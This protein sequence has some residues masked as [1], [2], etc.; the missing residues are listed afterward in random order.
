MQS[1]VREDP[2]SKSRVL[3]GQ[4]NRSEYTDF[5][6]QWPKTEEREALSG[7]NERFAGFIEKVRQLESENKVLENEIEQLREKQAT[8]STLYEGMCEAEIKELREIVCEISSQKTK[9]EIGKQNLEEDFS[10]LSGRYENEAQK[11]ANTEAKIA[12][13]K[14]DLS[15]TRLSKIDLETKLQ[16]LVEEI[17]LLKENHNQEVSELR[18]HIQDAQLTVEENFAKPDITATLKDIREQLAGQSNATTQ[19]TEQWF[20]T[21]MASMAQTAD[22]N[23]QALQ[24][25]KDH[26]QELKRQWRTKSGELERARKIKDKLEK[27]IQDLEGRHEVDIAQYRETVQLLENELQVT[28]A[29]IYGHLKEHQEL[30]NIKMA[31]DVEIT[32]YRKLLEDEEFRFCTGT[33]DLL[34][35]RALCRQPALYSVPS[36]KK[37][38][39][40]SPIQELQSKSIGDTITEAT[41][42]D[43]LTE[44]EDTDAEDIVSEEEKLEEKIPEIEDFRDKDVDLNVGKDNEDKIKLMDYAGKDDKVNDK[45]FKQDKQTEDM[46]VEQSEEKED[47]MMTTEIVTTS[48]TSSL[49]EQTVPEN[50]TKSAENETP[51]EEEESSRESDVTNMGDEQYEEHVLHVE[52]EQNRQLQDAMLQ[53]ECPPS[54]EEDIHEEPH[55]E[56]EISKES[57][58]SDVQSTE[59]QISHEDLKEEETTTN[60]MMRESHHKAISKVNVDAET[61]HEASREDETTKS[62]Q[63]YLLEDSKVAKQEAFSILTREEQ[64]ENDGP[65]ED[66]EEITY[67]RKEVS[68]ETLKT[69]NVEYEEIS[70]EN[71]RQKELKEDNETKKELEQ[72]TKEIG[73]QKPEMSMSPGK[74]GEYHDKGKANVILEDFKTEEDGST[75]RITGDDE[76]VTEPKYDQ[77]GKAEEEETNTL[78]NQTLS[79]GQ[80][81]GMEELE[82][83][84]VSSQVFSDDGENIGQAVRDTPSE[85]GQGTALSVQEQREVSPLTKTEDSSDKKESKA[86]SICHPE[87]KELKQVNQEEEKKCSNMV[88]INDEQLTAKDK[89]L[90][91]E[92]N[93]IGDQVSPIQI[94]EM[95]Q[96]EEEPATNSKDEPKDLQQEGA[97][98]HPEQEMA[99][100]AESAQSP[101]TDFTPGDH[102]TI[103]Q[104]EFKED[105]SC[106]QDIHTGLGTEET[107]AMLCDHREEVCKSST[108]KLH[109]MEIGSKEEIDLGK[110]TT[111]TTQEIL[112]QNEG[113]ELPKESQEDECSTTKDIQEQEESASITQGAPEQ[114]GRGEDDG[115]ESVHP[116]DYYKKM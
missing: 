19:Q 27:Q 37:Q 59:R 66:V 108:G 43:N 16:A 67:R 62:R 23:S 1:S 86:E 8:S 92:R 68:S 88:E 26:I 72:A 91:S 50:L 53:S 21:R 36:L 76:E 48:K 63:L 17:I 60:E 54:G 44:I 98:V 7:L 114:E 45:M 107:D 46:A 10:L 32:S 99:D 101:H 102:N 77:D 12:V 79:D 13:V 14:K 40:V 47:E 52:P 83:L 112:G 75:C 34:A 24:A 73:I 74:E 42:E 104:Q 3:P 82:E 20:K 81:T 39:P 30:L 28:K 15:G 95:G 113:M 93:T 5:A 31:L 70:K 71:Y 65:V 4:Q 106:K 57:A 18:V 87:K 35:P 6:T 58:D 69:E 103:A 89:T 38:K 51:K 115:Q 61:L 22:V 110:T 9:I 105:T 94:D 56:G 97:V 96:T 90:E 41:M 109:H 111:P 49:R 78:I 25:S 80:L 2:L 33:E 116:A 100:A 11:R 29:V 85:Y 84:E 64:D 55:I